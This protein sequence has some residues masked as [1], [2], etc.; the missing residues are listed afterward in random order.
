MML[1]QHS[2]GS[3]V[4]PLSHA[5][6]SRGSSSLQNSPGVSDTEDRNLLSKRGNLAQSRSGK[7]LDSS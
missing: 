2:G 1:K 3:G 4:H 7:S 5:P 6:S